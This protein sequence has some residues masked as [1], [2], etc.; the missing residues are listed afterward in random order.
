MLSSRTSPPS[1]VKLSCIELTEPF[2]AAVVAVA[3]SAELAIAEA[4]LL[5]FHVAGG[6]IDRSSARSGLPGT[7]A[8]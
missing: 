7:S 5:A 2:E 6:R 8:P 3:Q 4:D 1:G